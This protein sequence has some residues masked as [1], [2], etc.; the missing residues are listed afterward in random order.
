MEVQNQSVN[1]VKKER[2][3][4]VCPLET[5]HQM[6]KVAMFGNKETGQIG[7][8]ERMDNQDKLLLEIKDFTRTSSSFMEN[9]AGVSNTVT[10]IS[11]LK[12]PAIWL[13]A[14]VLG[15]LALFG[16]LKAIFLWIGALITMK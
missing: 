4:T 11:L 2:R 3:K 14:L 5:E 15:I 16:G 8:F 1:T 9:L 13:L 10:A 7:L 12:K 6:M